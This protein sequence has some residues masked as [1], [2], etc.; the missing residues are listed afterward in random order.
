[1]NRLLDPPQLRLTQRDLASAFNTH[2][3]SILRYMHDL[4]VPMTNNQA[5]GD[6]R[7]TKPHRKISGC[8][9]SQHGAERFA[10]LR[11]YLSTTREN[12][13]TAIDALTRLFEGN[14]WMPPQ[15]T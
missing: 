2:R 9:R 14:P 11:S 8:F 3:A 1:M 15:P 6:L 10:H 5:E 13:I 7:P 12:G 4:D